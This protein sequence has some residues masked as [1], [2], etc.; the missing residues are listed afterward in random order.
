[1]KKIWKIVLVMI[2]LCLNVMYTPVQAREAFTIDELNIH[3]VV[4]EDGVLKIT[5][6][7]QLEFQ[8]ER[9]GFYRTIPTSYEMNWN[10]EDEFVKKD[11]YF[12][13]KNI[14][15]EGSCNVEQASEGVSIR[16]GDAD[17][18]VIGNQNYEISYE[19]HTKDLDLD[20]L[21][22]LYW[23]LVGNGFDTTIKEMTYSI[24][25]PKAFAADQVFTY[26]GRYGEGY[27]NLTYEVNGNTISGHLNEPLASNESATIKVNLEND[28]FVFPERPSYAMPIAIGASI[29]LLIAII[30]FFRYGKDD[31]VIITVEFKAPDDLNSAG[32]GYVIDTMAD[33]KDVLS[34]I[35]DWANRGYLKIIEKD[36]QLTLEKL[37]DLDVST[38]TSYERVF[39]QS[40][41]KKK[42]V[43]DEDDLK[44][45]YAYKGL[46]RA[47]GEIR[48]YFSEKQNR[49]FTSKSRSLQF[50]MVLFVTLP[51]I[52]FPFAALY[53][54]YEMIGYGIPAFIIGAFMAGSLCLWILLMEKRFV[55]KKSSFF[56]FS[57]LLIIVDLIL[58]TSV[59]FIM[60]TYKE[61]LLSVGIYIFTTIVMFILMLFMDKRTSKGNRWLGQI[62]GLKEFIMSCEKERLE[63]LVNDNPSAFFDI[64]P[65]AYVLGVSDIWAHKFEDIVIASP[66][67]YYSDRGGMFS[68][69]LWWNYFSHSFHT[70]SNAASYNPDI[71]KGTGGGSTGGFGGGGFSGG[72]FSGG[73]FGGGGGGSW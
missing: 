66:E 16:L 38:S 20:G 30:L 46:E 35:M 18:Y 70:M 48:K 72:G 11:Y 6:N 61:S 29:L 10:V 17:R 26:T 47:K 9:H 2:L 73:G 40:I 13:I 39:F 42:D 58:I 1:M 51:S 43:V 69:F 57:I 45:G 54:Y 67:W 55:I 50:L 27:E 21:Q 8:Q 41:F 62:L 15:C 64:L 23:N 71:A 31:E 63:L 59:S 32:V 53:T 19:V 49:V 22:F 4:G 68:T 5:E 3:M 37:K 36:Q 33:N 28:Y 14:S 56:M 44:S 7:Y 12:P 52:I 65:Y 25:M 34:L 24:E 60:I